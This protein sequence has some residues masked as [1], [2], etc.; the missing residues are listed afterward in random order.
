MNAS[1]RVDATNECY[2][3]ERFRASAPFNKSGVGKAHVQVPVQVQVQVQVEATSISVC[4][5]VMHRE[6]YIYVA[7]FSDER[8]RKHPRQNKPSTYP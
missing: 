7:M 6:V 3:L 1:L 2:T 4:A 5:L 8:R